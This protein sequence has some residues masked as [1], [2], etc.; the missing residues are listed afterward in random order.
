[1]A[2]VSRRTFMGGAAGAAAAASLLA[3]LPQA[4]SVRAKEE[5]QP[6]RRRA[7]GDPDAGEPFVRP[8]LRHDARVRGFADEPRCETWSASRPAPPRRWAPAAVPGGT[9]P[10]STARTSATYCTTGTPPPGLE[11]RA[12]QPVDPGQVRDDHVVLRHRDIRSTGRW[13][14]RS[15]SATTTSARSKGRTTPNRLYHWTGTI[16]PDGAAG[17]PG[18]RQPARLPAGVQLDYLSGTAAGGRHLVA[19]VRQRRGRRRVRRRLRRQP[20]V[21]FT[22]TTTRWP[23]PTP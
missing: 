4:E 3:N 8:L 13:P 17:G 12:L 7:R 14:R 2:A 5:G 9:R 23:R 16:D 11:R 1:M 19:G 15:R 21:L 20:V 18:D 22:P 10:R 6:R